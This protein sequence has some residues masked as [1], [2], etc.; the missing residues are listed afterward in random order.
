MTSGRVIRTMRARKVAPEQA[1]RLHAIVATL[2]AE[3]GVPM[4]EVYLSPTSAP[5]ALGTSQ[6]VCVTEGLVD[7]LDERALRSVVAQVMS[8]ADGPLVSAAV[9]L[10][11]GFGAIRGHGAE[12]DA[13]PGPLATLWLA[14]VAPLVRLAAGRARVFRADAS[15][16][17][18]VVLARALRTIE[19][20]SARLPMAPSRRLLPLGALM[21]A[22]PFASPAAAGRLVR[23]FA[24][25]PPMAERVAR[26]DEQS[27]VDRVVRGPALAARN[28]SRSAR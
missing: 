16:N 9:G 7:L 17:D 20:G 6:V 14:A 26:L 21:V 28:P 4:P 13:E 8:R 19:V 25:H 15:G 11:A 23:W 10:A 18:P 24:T 27:G 1:L 5:N 3:R 12:D 2:A 22:N